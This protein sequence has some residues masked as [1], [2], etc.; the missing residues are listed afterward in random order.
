MKTLLMISVCVLTPLAWLLATGEIE[1]K[2]TLELVHEPK[3]CVMAPCPQYRVISVN[4]VKVSDLGADLLNFEIE[5]SAA[6]V[7]KKISVQ[8]EWTIKEGYLEVT[9]S[10]W[11]ALVGEK[12]QKKPAESP[13]ATK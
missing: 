8:G 10:E 3:V 2:G 11:H 4:G 9:A 5:K 13:A 6:S 12:I 7:F 1:T